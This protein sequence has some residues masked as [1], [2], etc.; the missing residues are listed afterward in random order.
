MKWSFLSS[1]R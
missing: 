1:P